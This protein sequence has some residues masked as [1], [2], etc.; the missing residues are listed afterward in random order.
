[1]TQIK[2][3]SL[4]I[5]EVFRSLQGEGPSVGQ[6]A[7]FMR[8]Q[9]CSVG[10]RWC[11]TKYSWE[12]GLGTIESVE[13]IEARLRILGPADLLVLTG[14][15]PLEYPEIGE[16]LAWASATWRRVEVETS[17]LGPPP[18]IGGNVS[19]NWSPKLP[20]ATPRWSETWAQS[21]VL[22][23]TAGS[24][25]KVVIDNESDWAEAKRLIQS[26]HVPANRVFVVPQGIRAD[27]VVTR[28]KWLA[29]LCLETGFHL[30]FRLHILLWGGRRGV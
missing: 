21:E 4:P 2:T 27:E 6:P 14:G 11:D 1:M 25:C 26:H 8:L 18:R 22:L 12:P 7:H 24:V 9:G 5:A 15:E 10:C 20:S 28:A 13:S 29:P 16:V 3:L 23:A 30:T 19:W 17:G